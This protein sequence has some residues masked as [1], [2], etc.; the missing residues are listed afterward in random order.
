MVKISAS[1]LDADFTCLVDQIRQAIQ[2]GADWLHLDIMD[3]NYVP[4]ISFGPPVVKA[5]RRMADVPLDVHLMINRADD[6]LIA[7][8]EAGADVLT[9]HYEVCP[10]LWRTIE[11]IKSLGIK[12]GVTLNPAT[13]VHLLEP[14]LSMVDLVLV[15]S[16]E[17]GFGGQKF[18]DKMLEKIR[19][20][21]E[22]KQNHNYRYH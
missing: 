20:L 4:N 14:V 3:G 1:I 9:V 22:Q 12:A 19:Y 17:P 13:P 8:Q 5:V 18:I 6:F 15:M 10:H 11:S 21:Y 7:F 2:G 16:V